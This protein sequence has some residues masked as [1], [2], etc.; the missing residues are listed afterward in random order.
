MRLRNGVEVRSS[1]TPLDTHPI[2]ESNIPCFR[3]M[4]FRESRLEILSQRNTYPQ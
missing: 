4:T 1:T 2:D 3:R